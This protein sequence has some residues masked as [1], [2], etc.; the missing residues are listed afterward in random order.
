MMRKKRDKRNRPVNSGEGGREI[1]EEEC[2]EK[3][4]RVVKGKMQ[5]REQGRRWR[6][7]EW[8]KREMQREQEGRKEEEQAES[9]W[10][11]ELSLRPSGQSCAPVLVEMFMST[12]HHWELANKYLWV[13]ADI[14]KHS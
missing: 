4:R 3:Q 13:G 5:R 11:L 8:R 7:R 9:T 12:S 1:K 6:N 14:C 10:F 2:G